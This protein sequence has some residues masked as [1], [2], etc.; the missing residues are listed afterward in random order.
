M[1][2]HFI[3]CLVLVQPRKT[4]KRPK[5]T[6]KLLTGSSSLTDSFTIKFRD[7]IFEKKSEACKITKHAKS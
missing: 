7:F 5:M 2:C 3:L 4:G 6:E 1:L